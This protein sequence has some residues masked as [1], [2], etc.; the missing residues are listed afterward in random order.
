MK[1][2]TGFVSNSSSSSF[3][4]LTSVEN[5]ER[6]CQKLTQEELVIINAIMLKGIKLFGRDTMTV[7][8]ISSDNYST[9]NPENFELIDTDWD[10]ISDCWDKYLEFI[11]E[12]PEE[13]FSSRID[14]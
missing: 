12:N 13:V 10:Y 11:K 14:F 3:V 5:H 6:V 8:I 4:I 1:I 2:R 7:N 9:L